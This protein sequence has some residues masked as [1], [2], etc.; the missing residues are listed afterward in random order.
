MKRRPPQLDAPLIRRRVLLPHEAELWRSVMDN[1]PLPKYKPEVTLAKPAPEVEVKKPVK[2]M[3]LQAHKLD[4]VSRSKINKG[5]LEIAATL[6]LHGF[7]VDIAHR[8]LV[9]FVGRLQQSSPRVVLVITG[10]GRAP[11]SGILRAQLPHWLE[12]SP[13]REQVSGYSPAGAAHG[14]EGAWYIK[15]RKLAV[16]K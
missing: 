4:N 3:K 8:M 13:L 16:K 6:D 10:K 5:K 9:Q 14:G 7:T 12:L 2:L 11:Q 15:I 1:S